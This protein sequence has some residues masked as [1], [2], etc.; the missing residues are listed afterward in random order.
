MK[1]YLMQHGEAMSKADNPE[2]PLNEQ[3]R[4]NAVKVAKFLAQAGV[5]ID[6]IRHSG[7]CRA[8]QTATIVAQALQIQ[9][10]VVAVDGLQP[11]DDIHPIANA[12][13]QEARDIMLVGHLPFLNRLA[14][15][16]LTGESERT[17]VQ[18]KNAGVIC[19]EYQEGIWMVA[20]IIIPEL[21]GEP[22][23]RS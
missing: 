5:Q 3:G 15:Y 20:W 10:A 1:L 22:Y 2:R 19:L 6:Q 4:N 9:D 16:L 23:L 17:I 8:E 11:N 12:L 14:S 18:F 21:M 13:R 7:K